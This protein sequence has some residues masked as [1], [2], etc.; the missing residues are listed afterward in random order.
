MAPVEGASPM[1]KATAA[2]RGALEVVDAVL[3]HDYGRYFRELRAVREALDADD[4][5]APIQRDARVEKPRKPPRKPGKTL[6]PTKL[7]EIV[8]RHSDIVRWDEDQRHLVIEDDKRL[9]AEVM[10]AF[11]NGTGNYTSFAR[12]LNYY[13]F[14]RL[15]AA[16]R[17]GDEPL[18]FYNKNTSVKEV[19]DLEKL[20]RWIAP[21]KEAESAGG[22]GG[23]ED[24]N[25]DNVDDA[26][27][28]WAAA[29]W[30]RTA[31]TIKRVR[32]TLQFEDEAQDAHSRMAKELSA[33]AEVGFA[34]MVRPHLPQAVVEDLYPR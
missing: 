8:S 18:V 21:G 14:N 9:V 32:A 6:F 17:Q 3:N 19:S 23:G 5:P 13:G 10:P 30:A 22:G 15:D 7:Y 29:S 31:I 34:R 2:R 28:A 33:L 26:S 20:V 4:A 27:D 12:Q 1:R 11:F 24:A 25:E 16:K